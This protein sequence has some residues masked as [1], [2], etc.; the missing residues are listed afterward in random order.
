MVLCEDCVSVPGKP[1]RVNLFGVLSNLDSLDDPPYPLLYREFCVFLAL[2]EG[3]AVGRGSIR[4]VFEETDRTVF[5]T[6]AREISFG[7]DPLAV[8]GCVFRLRDC[9]FPSP[10]IYTVQFWYNHEKLE[11]RPLRLR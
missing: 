9:R 4:C 7:P 5:W 8:V 2:T 3:R 6:P 11:E 10:G 1:N